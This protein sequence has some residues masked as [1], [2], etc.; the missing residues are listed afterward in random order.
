M[1]SP[2]QVLECWPADRPVAALVSGSAGAPS[3]WSRWSL[4]A[5]PGEVVLRPRAAADDFVPP[6]LDSSA[7]G[8][9]ARDP[10]SPPMTSGWIACLSYELGRVLEPLAGHRPDAD[11]RARSLTTPWPDALW[12]RCPAVLAFDH[13]AGR[14]W[15]GGEPRA[16]EELRARLNAAALGKGS[17]ARPWALGQVESAWSRPAYLDAVRRV[18]DYIHAGDVFQ[19]NLSH[20][21][22]AP[23]HGSARALAAR[24]WDAAQPWFGAYIEYPDEGPASG[25][26]PCRRAVI[27]TSPELLAHIDPIDRRIVTRPMKGTRRAGA[28]HHADLARSPKDAAE[29][30]MIIDLMRNDVGRVCVPGSVHVDDPRTI[31]LH[32]RGPA[33]VLQGVAT[34]RGTLRSDT[35]PADILRAIFPGGSVTGAPKIRA[36]QIIEELE[37]HARGPYCGSIG[38]TGDDGRSAWN[39]A[40][41]TALL[42]GAPATGAQAGALDEFAP[43]SRLDFPVGAGIVAAS[44]PESEWRE[45]LDKAATVI[46]LA[47]RVP[48]A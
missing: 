33:G 10:A 23:F 28:A 9:C 14:W 18:I 46:G 42:S 26:A 43:G 22:S 48:N 25:A 17:R 31:E 12:A 29:L 35:G 1:I 27:S 20:V 21:L 45:T 24:A 40:I 11:R 38:F 16:A 4:I 8:P 30:N 19:V 36:M 13:H 41:R 5:E 44:D 32:A 7:F 2:G 37:P 39:V 6:C 15:V 34:V 47:G 3:P